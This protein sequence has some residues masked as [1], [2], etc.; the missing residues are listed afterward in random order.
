MT[1]VRLGVVGGGEFMRFRA[2]SLLDGTGAVIAG[3]VE[4]SLEM[5]ELFTDALYPEGGGP[6]FFA[7]HRALLDSIELDGVVIAS[8]H[9]LHFEHVADALAAGCPALIYKPMVT[10]S[11]DAR[12]LVELVA[13]TGRAVSIAAEGIYSAEFRHVRAMLEAGELGDIQLATGIVAQD[14]LANVGGSWR[15]DPVLGGGGN[16]IDSGYHMLAALLHLTGQVPEEVFAYIDRKD[17]AVDVFVAASLRSTAVR[18]EQ[19]RSA[20]TPKA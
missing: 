17:Q 14:W 4:P 20:E 2:P 15:T 13:Q 16:L 18:S 8:R 6:P 7:D 10:S 19:S 9:G 12:R 3:V 1:D 11:A 5:R